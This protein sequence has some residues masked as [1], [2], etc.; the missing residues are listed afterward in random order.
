MWPLK[1][2]PASLW[3]GHSG[4]GMGA[5]LSS[6]LRNQDYVPN[7][8]YSF[9]LAQGSGHEVGLPGALC[10]FP[11]SKSYLIFSLQVSQVLFVAVLLPIMG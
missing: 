2:G 8:S 6:V 9:L 3:A 4:P 5:M 1:S 7:A 11:A 10:G